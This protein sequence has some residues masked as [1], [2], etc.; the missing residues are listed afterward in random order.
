MSKLTDAELVEELFKLKE[1]WRH[2]DQSR[3]LKL[4]PKPMKHI[5]DAMFREHID[6][7]QE[8]RRWKAAAIYLAECHAANAECPPKSLSKHNRKRYK[9]ILEKALELLKGAFP[10]FYHYSIL[11]AGPEK[12]IERCEKAME[13]LGV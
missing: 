7:K 6:Q 1:S 3:F 4:Y 5:M 11:D 2:E 13:D 12:T 9:G 10:P 8:L